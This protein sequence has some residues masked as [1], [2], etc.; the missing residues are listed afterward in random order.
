MS[1]R[2]TPEA[3]AG[4]SPPSSAARASR[5]RGPRRG[6][7]RRGT[8]GGPGGRLRHDRGAGGGR[9]CSAGRRRTTPARPGT[10]GSGRCPGRRGVPS[11]GCRSGVLHVGDEVGDFGQDPTHIEFGAPCDGRAEV[12]QHG[13]ELD[14]VVGV[15]VGA[16]PLRLRDL[17][18]GRRAR[19]AARR[20][21]R[22]GGR[23]SAP[24]R[25]RD[26]G[27]PSRRAPRRGRGG[28]SRPAPGSGPLA[29]DPLRT[30]LSP[31]DPGSSKAA[32]EGIPRQRAER[33][34]RD[35]P[36]LEIQVS[37]N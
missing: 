13:L 26:R 34:S 28:G 9:S 3:A 2:A 35:P 21:G 30:W 25:V 1:V 17:G 16:Q 29:F 14:R 8:F 7:A 23:R 33:A 15:G 4:Q 10:S 6:P 36:G 22:G 12:V 31:R 18:I 32:R 11:F 19:R 24:G 37:R 20:R 5:R 27:G